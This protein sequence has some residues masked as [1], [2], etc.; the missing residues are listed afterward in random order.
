MHRYS[1]Q[2]T[3]LIKSTSLLVLMSR[4]QFRQKIEKQNKQ[5]LVERKPQAQNELQITNRK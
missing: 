1:C 4:S 5:I 3:P 2:N